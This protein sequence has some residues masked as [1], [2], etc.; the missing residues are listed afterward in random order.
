MCSHESRI[1]D[2][3]VI[4][5]MDC[6][7][8]LSRAEDSSFEYRRSMCYSTD[9]SDYR[10]ETFIRVI[11]S[12]QGNERF[13]PPKAL[14]ATIKQSTVRSRDDLHNEIRRLVKRSTTDLERC[15]YRGLYRHINK[16]YRDLV[17]HAPDGHPR[18]ISGSIQLLKQ[19]F[20]A[21]TIAFDSL[22]SGRKNFLGYQAILYHLL[23]MNGFSPDIRHFR[24]LK[25][26][27]RRV[28]QN[29][30]LKQLF[31]NCFGWQINERIPG[32][33]F[34]TLQTIPKRPS[35]GGGRPRKKLSGV[36]ESQSIGVS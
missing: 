25:S 2:G 15:A 3:G 36:P 28:E 26:E 14:L 22:S 34:T 9:R 21:L 1:E 32:D 11:E 27:H 30:L 35:H 33:R 18:N 23:E 17:S 12:Y 7:E 20:T 8:Q 16:L 10:L 13:E 31:R 5:C 24:L 19:Q 4:C 6:G 29:R